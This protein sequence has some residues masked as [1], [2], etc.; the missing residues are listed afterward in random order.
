MEEFM[1]V[2]YKIILG[3]VKVY[4]LPKKIFSMHGIMAISG[5]IK[6]MV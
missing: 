1:K 5:K 2:C 4:I 6:K 3:K